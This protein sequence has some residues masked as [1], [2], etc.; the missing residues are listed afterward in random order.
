MKKFKRF[1]VFLLSLCCLFTTVMNSSLTTVSAATQVKVE[2]V[3]NG[4]QF[5][6]SGSGAS[7]TG[8][9]YMW[10]E[11]SVDVGSSLS[12]SDI[13]ISDPVAC[14]ENE[15]WNFVSWTISDNSDPENQVMLAGNLTTQ[16]MLAYTIP[17]HD[18]RIMA[19]WDIPSGDGTGNNGDGSGGNTD[20]G[21]SPIDV[22][23]YADGGEFT[24][25]G[26]PDGNI[27]SGWTNFSVQQ[28]G[29]IRSA[30]NDF[31]NAFKDGYLFD[32]W[33]E[34]TYIIDTN[35][36][37]PVCTPIPG[38]TLMTT[39]EVL[40]YQ[41]PS[42]GTAFVAQYT[43]DTRV[44]VDVCFDG[45]G[46]EFQVNFGQDS[47]TNNFWG[48]SFVVGSTVAIDKPNLS[49]SNPVF[50]NSNRAFEGWMVCELVEHKNDDGSTKFNWEQIAGTNI[51][52]TADAL[53]YTIPDKEI[54]FIAQYAGNDD[55][56]YSHV[57]INGYGVQFTY[58]DYYW[59]NNQQQTN[60]Y[61]TE[62]WGNDL[63]EDGTSIE[64]QTK[65]YFKFNS[66]P[67][68][69]NATFEGWMEFK[70]EWKTKSTGEEY[71]DYT[72]VSQKLY[73][74]AEMLALPVPSYDVAYVAKWSDMS[75]DDYYAWI[76][77]KE[78]GFNAEPG[79]FYYEDS[80]H[81]EFGN[82]YNGT[83]HMFKIGTTLASNGVV[84]K[85]PTATGYIFK[86]WK[87]CTVEF[88][89]NGPIFTQLPNTGFISTNDALNYVIPDYNIRFV[90]EWEKD[91]RPIVNVC[92]EGNGGEL[93][94]E[95]N[96]DKWTSNFYGNDYIVGTTV[97]DT[98][99]KIT[100][101]VFWEKTRGFEGW[102]ICKWVERKDDNGNPWAELV[103]VPNTK[104]LTTAEALAYEIPDYDI[105]FNA[106]WAG[107]DDDY[108]SQVYINGYHTEFT[109]EE[110]YWNEQNQQQEF[111][112]MTT[113]VWGNYLREDGS[114]IAA[115]TNDYFKLT[116]DPVK[117]GATFE[118]W[119]EFKVESEKDANGY[120]NE[121]YTLVSDTLYTTAQM[122]AKAIPTYD[123]AYV[124][125]WSDIPT[126]EYFAE[127]AGV[128][129]NANSGEIILKVKDGDGNQIE[130]NTTSS[131]CHYPNCY[132]IE[133]G[134]KRVDWEFIGIEKQCAVLTGWKIYAFDS[135]SFVEMPA[136]KELNVG[137]PDVIFVYFDT[138][139]NEKGESFDRYLG[140]ENARLE[141]GAASTKQL[142]TFKGIRN[143]HYA[144]AIWQDA[145]TAASYVQENII[146]PTEDK[147]GS[148]D[149]V[150]YCSVCKTEL[151]RETVVVNLTSQ[152]VKV[153]GSN[154]SFKADTKDALTEV[155]KE[156]ADKYTSIEAVEKALEITA[157]TKNK[158]FD[159]EKVKMKVVDVELKVFNEE[160]NTWELVDDKNFPANG[161]TIVLPYPEGTSAAN[162]ANFTFEI[163]HMI[164]SG[165]KAG[166]TEILTPVFKAEGIQV[167]VTSLSPIGIVYQENEK[168]L[169][170]EK[171]K[172]EV[173]QPAKSE[174]MVVSPKTDDFS[175]MSIMTI[176]MFAI[177]VSSIAIMRKKSY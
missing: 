86:G 97:A 88:S 164:T 11:E 76:K 145:H 77:N 85:D 55:D 87:I 92:F 100:N 113:E 140:M 27:S 62:C 65:D 163:V 105:V 15:G 117:S 93:S 119:L 32:G 26:T 123:V 106:K 22:M 120:W 25:W 54:R 171:N 39:L 57:Y 151:E 172:T 109:F 173:Q 134:T 176:M 157:T 101:P 36:G 71:E 72:L 7:M 12:A 131:E 91:T 175:M 46:G 20:S 16:E 63:R 142:F 49:I 110:G 17:N 40:N 5:D 104:I 43:K 111:R 167:T 80:L 143:Y 154:D 52:S 102:E 24:I 141:F 60:T 79:Q 78:V 89:E 70:V 161:V 150:I 98:G 50:W 130:I 23:V 138:Y 152:I 94:I 28:G 75:F 48:A 44:F 58:D 124:A 64:T 153:E 169:D 19:C 51:I 125:K 2:F 155:P 177:F 108:C 147:A 1:F 170:D 126:K 114:S 139:T 10:H 67:T 42:T 4:G 136:G 38:A 112:P 115:Q 68:K 174:T 127:Y 14:P 144:E 118:G 73:T 74:T 83:N 90:A 18:I 158:T 156:I 37:L 34:C 8:T 148:Y 149:K 35:S 159:S 47:F 96:Q 99:V 129:L 121:N 84:V 137:D 116:T 146:E 30:G 95:F 29:S 107:N 53:A 3:G 21:S 162:Y 135:Y 33:L 9:D 160:K 103:R 69:A 165:E 56:Y 132:T 82:C 81:G 168:V 166:Q 122:L 45:N 61:F 133:E 59:D 66:E 41:I 6:I 31:S 128:F 13:I